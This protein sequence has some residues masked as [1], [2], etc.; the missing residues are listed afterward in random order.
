MIKTSPDPITRQKRK[1]LTLPLLLILLGGLFLL[2]SLGFLL[3]VNRPQ[4][5][6]SAP[7]PPMLGSL[8]L[9][10]K[11]EGQEA[12]NNVAR[13]HGKEFELISGSVGHYGPRGEVTVW[14]TGAA[15]SRLAAQITEQMRAKI[16][17]GGSP[18]QPLEERPAGSRI[19]YVL[20]GMGQTHYY[21]QSNELVVW[22]AAP[23]GQAESVLADLLAFYPQR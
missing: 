3:L 12:L 9:K 18:F 23:A 20:S 7:L 13:L 11:M 22:L 17:E 2:S 10:N 8:A 19:I 21:F 16:A 1:P 4:Q 15:S 14:V 6:G 5:P